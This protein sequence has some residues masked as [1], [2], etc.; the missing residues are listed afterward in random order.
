MWPPDVVPLPA[1]GATGGLGHG[2]TAGPRSSSP[3]PAEVTALWPAA[4][5]QALGWEGQ[6]HPSSPLGSFRLVTPLI[7]SLRHHPAYTLEAGGATLDEPQL[8]RSWEWT[9][10]L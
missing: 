1:L 2:R 6:R 8:S 9:K 5:A 7:H 3:L 4:E 10:D